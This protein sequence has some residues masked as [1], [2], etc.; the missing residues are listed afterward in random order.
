MTLRGIT[1]GFSSVILRN[2]LFTDIKPNFIATRMSVG[3]AHFASHHP[4][5]VP[6]H[7]IQSSFTMC[8][9]NCE[10]YLCYTW[11]HAKLNV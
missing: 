10:Q 11:F 2:P 9:M 1:C 4:M 6:I 8:R 3:S 7:K 5:K